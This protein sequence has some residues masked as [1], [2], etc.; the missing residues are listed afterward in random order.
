MMD[1]LI[2]CRYNK[3]NSE[4]H[5]KDGTLVSINNNF[6]NNQYGKEKNRKYYSK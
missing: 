3:C 5:F 2:L 1:N 4:C 6:K